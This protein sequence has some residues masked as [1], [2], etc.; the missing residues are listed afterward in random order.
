[1]RIFQ[2]Q[3]TGR[4]LLWRGAAAALAL[5]ALAT[6][7]LS[8]PAA[9]D[10]F[11]NYRYV[12]LETGRCLDSNYAGDVY[13]LPCNGGNYQRWYFTFNYQ[14]WTIRNNQ[15]DRCLDSNYAGDVYTLPCNGGN[16]QNWG[17]INTGV[18]FN[19][20]TDLCLDSNY[21][22]DVYTLGRN[23]GRYQSWQLSI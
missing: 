1:M 20:Q 17:G 14:R 15:T 10:G 21:A 9:A 6:G 11:P 5:V 7:A 2:R 8:A 19:W 22:G 23:G 18:L 13:T 4:R 12:N 16:Y 3:G